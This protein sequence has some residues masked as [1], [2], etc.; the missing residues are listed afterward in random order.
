M[1]SFS[2]RGWQ[3]LGNYDRSNSERTFGTQIYGQS[4]FVAGMTSFLARSVRKLFEMWDV[5][6]V[7]SVCGGFCCS[8]F[9][10]P[11]NS[12]LT[13]VTLVFLCDLVY[14]TDALARGSKQFCSWSSLD[15]L[16][17]FFGLR[18]SSSSTFEV[19]AN[20]TLILSCIPYHFLVAL[21]FEGYGVYMFLCMLRA[22]RLIKSG[23]ITMNSTFKPKKPN[24][25]R[26]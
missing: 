2:S 3:L 18:E 23:R 9:T 4:R 19:Y 5:L 26:N 16:L 21:G 25:N 15:N 8:V 13:F 11:T 17:A 1:V 20:A 7:L 24:I 6:V 14:I 22:R 10:A 12:S